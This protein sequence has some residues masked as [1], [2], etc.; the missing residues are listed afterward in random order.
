MIAPAMPPLSWVRPVMTTERAALADSVE[1]APAAV[2]VEERVAVP[3]P[4]PVL[5]EVVDVG[6]APGAVG[7][8][9]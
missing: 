5:A 4:V 3:V 8:P 2:L 6:P 7:R 9:A 1:P